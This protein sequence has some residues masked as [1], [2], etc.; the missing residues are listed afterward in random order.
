MAKRMES[1]DAGDFYTAF[2]TAA[3]QATDPQFQ[4]RFRALATAIEP[5][6][7]EFARETVGCGRDLAEVM[8]DLAGVAAR[9]G[10]CE[11]PRGFA[12]E[13]DALHD[14]LC[15]AIASVNSLRDACFV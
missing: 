13:C 4:E 10:Y 3:D 9:M 14:R 5:L 11:R 1:W 6:Q 2:Q 7:R 8:D 15:R 12:Q